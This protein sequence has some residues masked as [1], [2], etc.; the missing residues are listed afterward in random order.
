MLF[1][2]IDK[3]RAQTVYGDTETLN[4]RTARKGPKEGG[5]ISAHLVLRLQSEPGLT[6]NYAILEEVEGLS[7]S[8]IIPYLRWLL[9]KYVHFTTT[10]ASGEEVNVKAMLNDETVLDRPISEQLH[11]SQLLAVDVYRKARNSTID[12]SVEYYE[13]TRLIEYRP[14]KKVRGLAAARLVKSMLGE[15]NR[16]EYPEV[17]I[18]IEE[19]GGNQRTV[20]VDRTKKDALMSAFQ[21]RTFVAGIDPPLEEA[22]KVVAPQLVSLIKKQFPSLKK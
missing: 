3:D 16:Q 17:R 18:R 10:N 11:S 19:N 6:G 13:K 21:L 15:T 7:K 2:G 4:L 12:Q 14:L 9:D 8:S 1:L 22:S 5:A 20:G